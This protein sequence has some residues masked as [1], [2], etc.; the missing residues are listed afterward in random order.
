MAVKPSYMVLPY[1]KHLVF[2]EDEKP[3]LV[4]AN[5]ENTKFEV[6]KK[7]K[8]HLYSTHLSHR[9]VT[10]KEFVFQWRISS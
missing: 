9:T 4:L 8:I 2:H 10:M 1:G 5:I 6:T 7:R 3:L